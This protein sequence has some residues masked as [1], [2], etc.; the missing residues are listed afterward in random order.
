MESGS[1]LLDCQT[2]E[3]GKDAC[4]VAFEAQAASLSCLR[5]AIHKTKAIAST[6]LILLFVLLQPL[7]TGCTDRDGL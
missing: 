3:V 2:L 5:R 6:L 4:V 7:L 1:R